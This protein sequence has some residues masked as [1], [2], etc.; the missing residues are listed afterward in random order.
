MHFYTA[1]GLPVALLGAFALMRSDAVA[2]FASMWLTTFIDAS[3]GVFA[4]RFEV[5]R[6][7]PDFDG[8]KLD[9]LIDFLTFAF[10]PTLAVPALGL[11]PSEWALAAAVPLMASGYGFCQERAKTQESF[12]GFPSYW[13]IVLL[14][15]YV[16]DASP[17]TTIVVLWVLSVLVF[18][19]I[20]YLYPTKAKMW[21]PVTVGG[22]IVWAA[23]L[24]PVCAAPRADWAYTVTAISLIYPA[25]YTVASLVHHFRNARH[26]TAVTD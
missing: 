3:D 10:L 14:Y 9:D 18:V 16:L 21:R 6:V 24:A 26:E 13:N 22:G 2:F 12:V 5:R 15:L 8:R 23:S 17:V 11:V 20:H 19:P 7:L 4:R 1:L 25:Y